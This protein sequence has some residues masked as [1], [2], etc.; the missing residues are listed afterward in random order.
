MDL[1]PRYM[2]CVKDREGLLGVLIRYAVESHVVAIAENILMRIRE[3]HILEMDMLVVHLR[4]AV[5]LDSRLL[6]AVDRAVFDRDVVELAWLCC[7]KR[8][9]CV[10]IRIGRRKDKALLMHV[11]RHIMAEQDITAAATNTG[12]CLA[13]Q[14]DIRQVEDI[15]LALQVLDPGAR[16]A[17]DALKLIA[18]S[19]VLKNEFTTSRPLPQ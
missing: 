12:A 6:R 13:A 16:M 15:I 14:A 10:D 9:D 7:L 5:D 18:S 3:L 19:P 11:F 17:A 1:L 4:N 8:A 2:Q